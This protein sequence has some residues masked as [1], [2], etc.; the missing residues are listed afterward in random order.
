MA[1][2]PAV[3][4]K[5]KALFEGGGSLREVAAKVGKHYQTILAW[6]KKEGWV[7]GKTRPILDQKEEEATLEAARE[8]GLT[9]G[10]F[11]GK[12]KT[13]CEAT[14][15][16]LVKASKEDEAEAKEEGDESG[17]AFVQEVPDYKAISDGLTHAERII[18]GL[19][20]PDKVDL[21]TNG[22]SLLDEVLDEA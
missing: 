10:Y 21:T 13:L 19:K 3:K 8:L 18:P 4:A 7:Q 14:K 17:G 1:K 12:V 11:L 16:V 20:V 2:A 9:K 15:P 5:A 22:R 6:S